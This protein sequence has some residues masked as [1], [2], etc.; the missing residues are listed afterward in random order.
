M[1]R[2]IIALIATV[3]FV[4]SVS[5]QEVETRSLDELYAAAIK[6]GGKLVIWSG[7]DK[8][9]QR[10][11]ILN[12]FKKRFPKIDLQDHM[13][14]SKYHDARFDLAVAKGGFVPDLLELQTLHDFDYWKEKELLIRYRP[15]DW[16]KVYPDYKD[17]DGFWTGLYGVSFSNI[18]NI[19]MI[20]ESEAPRDALDYLNPALKG[21]I[22]LTYP[23][24]DDAVLYQFWHLQKKYGWEYIEK[25]IANE[26]LWLRGT[27]MP[28]VAV[29]KGWYPVSFTTSWGFVPYPNSDTRFL[30]PKNDFFLTWIQSAAIPKGAKHPT[31][32]KLYLSFVLSKEF[33]SVWYQ[34]PVRT[35]VPA[36]GGY[37]SIQHHNTSPVDF[38]NFMR[39]RALVER[40]KMQ[41]EELIGPA[42]G[43]NPMVM[44][45]SKKP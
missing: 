16:D 31:A 33:Q 17:P 12:A 26:P 36:P 45:Y 41:I 40:F 39:D 15:L 10:D 13:D 21:K 37:K 14:L 44:D 30:L 22:I 7:G 43:I 20:P 3:V 18:V 38:H 19:S 23:H 8:P 4:T 25:L 32:A 42:K 11:Q 24:D 28:Y 5:A 35:D 29:D 27:A 2:I 9:G 1:K 34:W 6:E